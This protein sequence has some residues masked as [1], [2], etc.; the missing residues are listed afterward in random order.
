M[1]AL[2]P[3]F[4][5]LCQRR[6]H[7]PLLFHTSAFARMRPAAAQRS[8]PAAAELEVAQRDLLLRSAAPGMGGG[9]NARPMV[10][11]K[12]CPY[13]VAYT[14]EGTVRVD[15]RKS[16]QLVGQTSS[17][18]TRAYNQDRAEFRPLRIPGMVAD[19]K[20]KSSAQLMY[21]GVYDG[22]G[23]DSCSEY[24]KQVLHS[25]IEGVAVS[26]LPPVLDTMRQ[27]GKDW[28]DYT[29]PALRALEDAMLRCEI[30]SFLTIDERITLA[31]LKADSSIRNMRWSDGQGSTACTV[32]LWDS[33]GL[34]FWSHDSQLNVVVS[35]VGDSKAILC[36]VDSHGG[37]AVPLNDLHHPG[38][39]DERERLQ[40]HGAFFSRDSFGEERAMARVAN[41][42]AFGDWQV[43]RFGV[44]AEPQIT[45]FD[46]QGD[47]AA[48]IVIV[49]DGL[50]SVL[51]DQEIVDIVKG[52]ANPETGARKLVDVAERL[53]SDDNMTAQVV[54]LPGWD[55][56]M[57]DLTAD[58]RNRRLDSVDRIKR[59]RGSMMAGPHGSSSLHQEP[60]SAALASVKLASPER[61]LKRIFTT[62]Q[63]PKNDGN[64]PHLGTQSQG[65]RLTVAQIQ[66]RVR[67][68]GCRLTLV[69][70]LEDLELDTDENSG[71][72]TA[73][74]EVMRM[75]LSVLGKT[76]ASMS[77]PP[78]KDCVL[79]PEQENTLLSLQ[80]A[81][82]AWRLIGLH[83]I[84]A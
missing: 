17:R 3:V 40:R 15:V 66:Q 78:L 6:A 73:V 52:C 38:V 61:L 80:D 50:T 72:V 43:K 59:L 27:Y 5:R 65:L 19:R 44:I 70:E 25:N 7:L 60:R 48:F 14:E 83:V 71:S 22:H 75:T 74:P 20:D 26:D 21:L 28:S 12:A 51:T 53:G 4:S 30:P 69:A 2:T 18:G 1:R 81:D 33:E 29:P 47:E 63:R 13:Y 82:K 32:L 67:A 79:T 41:T 36:N 34:P 76:G 10:E 8:A 49:S 64:A 35:S 24:L 57:L 84:E 54:R 39:R 77:S 31:F 68:S 23:G 58:H 55:S 42:R 56:P 11:I 9:G 62:H 37:L 45:H 46:I 16:P